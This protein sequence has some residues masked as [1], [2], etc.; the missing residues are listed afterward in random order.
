MIGR[1]QG[2]PG[3]QV[4]VRG[5]VDQDEV[6]AVPDVGEEGPEASLRLGWG[7]ERPR[8]VEV[9]RLPRAGN[10]VDAVN[11]G[12][13]DDLLGEWVEAGVDGGDGRGRVEAGRRDR[14]PEALG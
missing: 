1:N 12:G 8:D 3:A 10:Q 11:P 2:G 9:G 14:S 5:A 4:E 13:L 6:V 7:F